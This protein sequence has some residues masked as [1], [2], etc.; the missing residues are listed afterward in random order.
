MVEGWSKMAS[1]IREV[2]PK[3]GG[4]SEKITINLGY[5]DLGHIDLL[6]RD[7]FYANRTDF[8]CTA[9]RNQLER[10]ADATGQSVSRRSLDLGL[11]AL[12]PRGAGERTCGAAAIRYPGPRPCHDRTGRH[13]GA[14]P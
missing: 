7:S 6:V 10:H 9:I 13:T 5:I 2:W 11:K 1:N 8:I 14:C 12:Q 3:A 4:E